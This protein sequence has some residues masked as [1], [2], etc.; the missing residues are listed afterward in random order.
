MQKKQIFITGRSTGIGHDAAVYLSKRGHEA[1]VL[2]LL[3]IVIK[4]VPYFW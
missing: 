1:R 2:V 3:G 4:T